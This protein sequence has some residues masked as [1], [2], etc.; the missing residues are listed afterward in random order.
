MKYFFILG[1][2]PALSLSELEV[3]VP[4][5]WQVIN[6]NI[7]I[8]DSRQELSANL[9]E[10]VGGT[11]KFG[12]VSG[13]LERLDEAGA[14]QLAESLLSLAPS[15]KKIC[16]GLSDYDRRPISRDFGIKIKRALQ[17][18]GRSVR[19]VI[20]RD[21]ALSSVVVEQN[22]LLTTGGELVF[23]RQ[24]NLWCYGLTIGVQPFKALSARDFG[25]PARDDQS[26][27]LPPKVAQIML[28]LADLKPND[29]LLD[30]FC[31]S[32][33]VIQEA[34]LLGAKKII[35]ADISAKAIVD[36][37]VNWQWLAERWSI[38]FDPE[39]EVIDARQIA[40]IIKPKSIDKLVTEPY[41]GPQRGRRDFAA[42][43]RE[44]SQLYSEALKE[45]QKIIAPGGRVVM[46]W[47]V[48]MDRG[49]QHYVRPNISGWQKVVY[50][51][52][53]EQ[54]WPSGYTPDGNLLYGRPGQAVWRAIVGLEKS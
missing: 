21:A 22:K 52:L 49:Q 51:R 1:S 43:A 50:S 31:G 8:L 3:K 28:N 16:F 33:T 18:S 37:Q 54:V 30:P 5:K 4:G 6:Q 7:A 47:P 35:G 19:W 24:D 9:L 20:S 40:E 14:S 25:R 13:E 10:Q 34:G 48:F 53:A 23:W 12:R 41:L 11:I 29:T 17:A 46:I 38:D 26:G 44:L 15:D 27:M 2:H 45:W 39:L 32:G 42:T 36:S